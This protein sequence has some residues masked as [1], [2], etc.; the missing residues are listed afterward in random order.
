[1]KKR[2][3]LLLILMLIVLTTTLIACGGGGDDPPV[4]EP[5]EP[6]NVSGTVDKSQDYWIVYTSEKSRND[7]IAIYNVDTSKTAFYMC[8]NNV[9][10]KGKFTWETNDGITVNA[11][12]LIYSTDN[13]R[14]LPT[15]AVIYK[16]NTIEKS[17]IM[18]N[19]I[20]WEFTGYCI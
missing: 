13:T 19:S 15:S 17:Y 12:N 9:V 2:A 10:E 4:E 8:I 11:S 6:S 20:K 7:Y 18:F 1:M 14:K 3:L 5:K 16:Y